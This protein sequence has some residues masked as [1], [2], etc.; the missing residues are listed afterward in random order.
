[1]N[2]S[3]TETTEALHPAWLYFTVQQF[4]KRHIAFSV[5]SLRSIIFL[6]SK[7]LQ[8]GEANMPGVAR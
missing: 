6:I 7:I 4:S 2:T 3:T 8:L 5:S 1:M